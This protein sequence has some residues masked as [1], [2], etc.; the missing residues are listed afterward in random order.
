MLF[1]WFL[2]AL[3]LGGPLLL[4]WLFSTSFLFR[5]LTLMLLYGL[6]KD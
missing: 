6:F 4:I 2:V 3:L 1:V 5:L